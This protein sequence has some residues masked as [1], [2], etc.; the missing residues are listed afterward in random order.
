MQDSN[1][2]NDGNFGFNGFFGLENY[3]ISSFTTLESLQKNFC[4]S[5]FHDLKQINQEIVSNSQVN[6]D[7]TNQI[8]DFDYNF[9]K[10]F[11]SNSENELKD[12]ESDNMENFFIN[13]NSE[14]KST[15]TLTI[16]D[17]KLPL[18][19]NYFTFDNHLA[20]KQSKLC[21]SQNNLKEETPT[22]QYNTNIYI[23]KCLADIL[24]MD[25]D[26][27]KKFKKAFERTFKTYENITI[28]SF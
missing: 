21:L 14:H 24:K 1:D 7:L 3:N 17:I 20:E 8:H 22:Q 9:I 26:K 12:T 4:S 15:K 18:N 19:E 10:A 28:F 6:D 13:N 11:N 23:E 16:H 2:G 25:T 27:F 5:K